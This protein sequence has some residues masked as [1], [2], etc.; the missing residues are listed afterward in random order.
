MKILL[1]AKHSPVKEPIGGVQSWCRTVAGELEKRGHDVVTW[2]RRDPIPLGGF[3]F[4]I[5]SNK[6]DTARSF[7]WCKKT[8]NVCHGIIPAEK[9]CTKCPTVFTSEEVRDFWKGDAEIVRQPIDTDF[10]SPS[11]YPKTQLTRCSYRSGLRFVPVIAG[12][13]KLKYK[14]VRSLPEAGVRE[15]LRRSV[16][17]LA[18]GRAALEAMSCGVPVVLVDHRRSYQ[19]PLMDLDINGAMT[20]NYSGRGGITPTVVNVTDAIVAAI[21]A[22]SLRDHVLQHH[23]VMKITDQLLEYA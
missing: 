11:D 22:G 18:T 5:I 15:N 21:K 10:W 20:R 19:G 6:E 23:D 12:S 17:V 13:M 1:A 16:C 4:G 8:V 3:D 2:G 7:A 14:H 9:P